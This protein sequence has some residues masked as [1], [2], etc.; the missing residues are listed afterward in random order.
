MKKR[1]TCQRRRGSVGEAED[2][3]DDERER[4]EGEEGSGDDGGESD[5]KSRTASHG[6]Q[7]TDGTGH[8]RQVTDGA[9]HGVTVAS[10]TV[11]ALWQ[12]MPETAKVMPAK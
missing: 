2:D 5:G 10:R 12:R 9:G 1:K 7:V 11:L 4:R 3:D 8:G 6:R